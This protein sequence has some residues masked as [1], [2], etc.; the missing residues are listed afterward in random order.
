MSVFS[1]WDI[2]NLDLEYDVIVS[3]N[4]DS[5]PEYLDKFDIK[6]LCIRNILDV[7]ISRQKRILQGSIVRD[8][9]TILDSCLYN[10]N[11]LNRL[12]DTPDLIIRYEDY[13]I[14]EIK[15]II[16]LLPVELNVLEIIEIMKDLDKMW[17][18]K[19]IV[20]VDNHSDPTY[21]KTLLT[22]SH[23]TSQGQSNKFINLDFLELGQIL[24]NE[25]VLKFLKTYQYI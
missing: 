13:S 11:I 1:G 8:E 18:S 6:I 14:N 12:K 9:K 23:N 21:R 2:E 17:Q 15:K 16:N 10:I 4:H 3:K 20:M 22:Q 24:E 7:G 25:E 19:D 5:Q